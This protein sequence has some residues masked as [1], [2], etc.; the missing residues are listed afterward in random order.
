MSILARVVFPLPLGQAFLY[1]VPPHLEAKAKP[2]ARVLVPLGRKNQRGFI[3]S[4]GAQPP[5]RGIVIK[6]LIDVLDG[7]PLW[8][9][10]FLSFT[11]SLSSEY[12]SS[13]GEM[14][15]A[16]LPPSL[17]LRVRTTV[18]AT[19]A[20]RL[21][22]DGKGLGPKERALAAF[23]AGRTGGLSPVFLQRKLGLQNISLLI[24]RLEKKG[25]I[26]MTTKAATATPPAPAA[27]DRFS[28]QLRLDFPGVS[29]EDGGLSRV[30]GA[31][32]KDAFAAFYLF[33]V[34]RRLDAAYQGLL[35]KAAAG[36]GKTLFLVPEVSLTRDLVCTFATSFGRSAAVFH[37][38]MTRKQREDAWRAVRTGRASIVAGTRSALFI[39][40]GPLRC[41]V[42]D[43]EHEESYHQAE[44]PAYDARRGA[45]LRAREERA[46]VIFGSPRPTVEA[47]YEAARNKVLIDLGSKD[48]GPRV[49]LVDHRD[50]TRLVSSELEGKIRDSVKRDSPVILFLNRR[51]YAASIVCSACGKAPRCRRCDLPLIFHKNENAL[52]CH[53]CAAS[54]EA[55]CPDCGGRLL[56]PK[57]VGIQ[58][59]EEEIRAFLPGL[60]IARF[61][62]DTAAGRE[63]RERILKGYSR[64]RIPILIGTQ[65]LAHQS[66]VPRARLVGIL[67]PE[68]LLGFSDYHAAQKT[69]QTVA[70]MTEFCDSADGGE[71]VVQTTSP[72]HFSIRAAADGDYGMFYDREIE[73][74]RMMNYPPFTA[75]AEIT[76]MGRE[77]RPLAAKSRQLKSLL[78]KHQPDVEI[79]GPAFAPIGRIKDISRVQVI[80][81]S[82]SREVID[83]ALDE[84]LPRIRLRKSVVFSYSPFGP[85]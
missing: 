49:S 31:L 10:R 22:L 60:P 63:E 67:S 32:E 6:D 74:R 9:E 65:L 12:R 43:G 39:D 13:W 78:E 79:L 29:R 59:L 38:R 24:R 85:G 47:F 61:D 27:P 77:V 5:P 71:I 25:F 46:V 45:W 83:R 57:G 66:A 48:V 44:S 19:E 18:A 55:V 68:A 11:G 80:L 14:L 76:L 42:V 56:H 37:G 34:R 7:T 40:P 84:T 1:S 69:F 73:F 36:A 54:L 20:G 70:G 81:K 58:A 52:V 3:V 82:R 35:R 75:L 2:G 15:E 8:N 21:A 64:G 33:G 26:S 28:L 30:A 41:I 53:S 4:A 72:C 50:K 23:L 17:A 51:G 62:S 16:S